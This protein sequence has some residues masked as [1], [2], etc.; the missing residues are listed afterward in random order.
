M[1]MGLPDHD[2]LLR[3]SDLDPDSSVMKQNSKKNLDSYCFVTL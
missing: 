2:P 1:F 3:R